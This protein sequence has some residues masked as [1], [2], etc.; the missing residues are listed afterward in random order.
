M[1]VVKKG[2]FLILIIFVLGAC[3]QPQSIK[4][5]STIDQ[6]TIEQIETTLKEQGL[7]LEG[8]SLPSNNVFIQPLNNIIPIA[9]FV[10]GKTLSIYVF[11][12]EQEREIGMVEFEE[13]TAAAELVIHQTYATKNILIYYVDGNEDTA[14]KINIAINQLNEQEK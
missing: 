6:I 3:S 7:K 1:A 4:G 13:K 11:P 10:G 14:N 12:N 8:S 5:N 9:Y 2:L